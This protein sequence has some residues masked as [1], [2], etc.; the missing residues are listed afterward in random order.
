MDSNK[1]KKSFRNQVIW[2]K[3]TE[4]QQ[5]EWFVI[6]D[7]IVYDGIE[8]GIEELDRAMKKHVMNCNLDHLLVD[9]E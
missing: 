1:F 9:E 2:E 8:E 3:M 5:E 4:E 7:K 6:A